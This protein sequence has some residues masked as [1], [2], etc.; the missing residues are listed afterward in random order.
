M[1]KSTF[2]KFTLID[3]LDQKIFR[4]QST[5][6]SEQARIT[7]I[8]HQREQRA[9]QRDHALAALKTTKDLLSGEESDL[10]TVQQNLEKSRANQL[11]AANQQQLDAI[12]KEIGILEPK[13]EESEVIILEL[14]E[15]VETLEEGIAAAD[16]FLAGSEQTLITIKEEVAEIIAVEQKEIEN[17]EKEIK[18]IMNELNPSDRELLQLTLNR[19]RFKTPMLKIVNGSCAKCGSVIDSL[20]A[21]QVEK[22]VTLEMCPGCNRI[23]LPSSC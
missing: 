15:K 2:R 8:V 18:L 12:E 16:E 22:A 19:Y 17:S 1:D 3:V 13:Q 7:T 10:F 14:M 6:D 23:L 21:S 20:T 5:V 4:H 9:E 11:T